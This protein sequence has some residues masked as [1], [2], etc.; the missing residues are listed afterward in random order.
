MKRLNQTRAGKRSSGSRIDGIFH[1]NDRGSR[2]QEIRQLMPWF[3]KVGGESSGVTSA[4][5]EILRG[6]SVEGMLL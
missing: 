5:F 4:I 1:E 6:G 3:L 2:S